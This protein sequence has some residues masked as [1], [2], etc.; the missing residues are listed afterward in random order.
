MKIVIAASHRFHLLDLAKELAALGHDVKFYSYVPTKRALNYGLKKE[1]SYSLYYLMLP[2]LALWKLSKGAD[3]TYKLKDLLLDNY[4]AFFMPKCDVYIALGTVYKKSL[5]AAKT[6]YNAITI[7]EWGSKH[8]IEQENA[9]ATHAAAK[10]QNPYF[11]E[12]SL[13]GYQLADYIAIPTEHVKHS[14]MKHGISETKLLINPYGVGLSM[15]KPTILETTKNYDVL[16]V[17]NWSYTK[18]SDFI[19]NAITNTNLTFLHIGALKALPFPTAPNFTHIDAVDQK[20]LINYYAKAKV[21]LLPSRAEGLSMV[22]AQAIACGLPIVCSKDTG[23]RDL[24]NLLT[25]QKWI[26]ELENTDKDTILNAINQA[27]QLAATQTGVR[28]YAQTDL[29]KLSWEAY[30]RRYSEMIKKLL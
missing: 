1:N 29:Q 15:F 28:D 3:W 10:R 20:Q 11:I 7:L 8:I 27:L 21:F 23:G 26:I 19:I 18:G 4:M 17:G 22:Q 9:I 2:F 16:M 30:G 24:R 6:K 14:F 5:I 12:R 13:K 25:D